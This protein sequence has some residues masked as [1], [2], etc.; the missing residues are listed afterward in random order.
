MVSHKVMFYQGEC[1]YS[2][3]TDMLTVQNLVPV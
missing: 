2:P 3:G 1:D